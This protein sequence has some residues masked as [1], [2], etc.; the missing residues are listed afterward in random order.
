MRA[1]DPSARRVDR[2]RPD[3]RFEELAGILASGL[4]R[5]KASKVPPPESADSPPPKSPNSAEKLL[6]L[7]TEKRLSA[8]GG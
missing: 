4:L 8:S 6:E 7:S 2:L 1:I 3:E 5:L